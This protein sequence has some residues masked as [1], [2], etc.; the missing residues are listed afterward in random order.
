MPGYEQGRG[1]NLR[2]VGLEEEAQALAAAGHEQ[3]MDR[4]EDE[5]DKEQRHEHF[6]RAFDALLHAQRDHE[7]RRQGEDHRVE[8]RPPGVADEVREDLL[9]LRGRGVAGQVARQ[10]VDHVFG[11]PARDHEV[12]A[13]NEEGRQH[14]DVSQKTPF[15]VEGAEGPHGVAVR[16]AAYGELREHQRQSEQQDTEDIDDQKG[17][18]AVVS[19]D[20]GETPDV[21]QTYRTAGCD[22]HGAQ[23]PAQRGAGCGVCMF[24]GSIVLSRQTDKRTADRLREPACRSAIFRERR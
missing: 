7:M 11:R 22:Q 12:E 2:E 16:G 14:A 10:R 3:R 13:Q 24:H 6:G 9:I 15:R 20:V 1:G 18:A 17:A 19:G 5:H 4:E 21:S 23:L 8:Q